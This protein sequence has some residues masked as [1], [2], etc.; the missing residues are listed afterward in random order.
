M[1]SI[2]DTNGRN[3]TALT[4]QRRDRTGPQNDAVAV[5]TSDLARS[6]FTTSPLNE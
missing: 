1:H 3:Q 6:L 2:T 5:T 4:S